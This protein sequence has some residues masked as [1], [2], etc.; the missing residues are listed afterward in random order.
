[1]SQI[2]WVLRAVGKALGQECSGVVPS[3]SYP[4]CSGLERRDL[5]QRRLD[6]YQIAEKDPREANCAVREHSIVL[7][8]VFANLRESVRKEAQY[9]IPDFIVSRLPSN[10]FTFDVRQSKIITIKV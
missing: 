4:F 5:Q 10:A 7:T 3:S 8:G 6:E 2:G 1:M 9:Q